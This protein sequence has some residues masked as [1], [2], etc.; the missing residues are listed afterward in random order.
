[1][2][3]YSKMA[4]NDITYQDVASVAEQVEA[5]ASEQGMHVPFNRDGKVEPGQSEAHVPLPSSVYP[6]LLGES[7]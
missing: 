6:A 4:M 1:M 7:K 2:A 3:I 5:C